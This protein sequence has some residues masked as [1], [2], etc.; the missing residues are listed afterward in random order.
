M[1]SRCT[2]VFSGRVQG[3]GFRWTTC[4]CAKPLAVTGWVRNEPDGTVMLVAEGEREE[5]NLLIKS[6]M[7]QLGDK[8]V[9]D[10]FLWGDATGE[11]STFAISY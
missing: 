2:A 4:R 6:L 9:S 11:F 8:I 10:S 5:I 1:V 7:E 3:V